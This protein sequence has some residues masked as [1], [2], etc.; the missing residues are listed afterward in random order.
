MLA[1]LFVAF[2]VFVRLLPHAWSFT[3]VGAALLFFGARGSRKL[4]WLP[5]VALAASDVFLTKVHYGYPLTPDHYVTWAWYAAI[6]GL[7]TL[8]GRNQSP[9]R[10]FGASL[11]TAIS[12]FVVSNFAV[13]AV[14]E[15]YP[16]TVAGLMECYT[17]GLPFFRNEVVSDVLFTAIMFAIPALIA[18]RKPA[19]QVA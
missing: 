13:W 5:I 19:A 8:L 17:M 9:A 6:L 4:M 2:A 3:P 16:K 14:W 18:S 1:L 15:M 12:F 11:A 7:G 10:I